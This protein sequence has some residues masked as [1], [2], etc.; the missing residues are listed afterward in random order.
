MSDLVLATLSERSQSASEVYHAILLKAVLSKLENVPALEAGPPELGDG[1]LAWLLRLPSS[2]IISH[3]TPFVWLN[4]HRL[5]SSTTCDDE[6]AL[7]FARHLAMT[8]FDAYYQI[9]PDGT[10]VR[11]KGKPNY[12]MVVLPDL[13]IQ[14]WTGASDSTL[15]RSSVNTLTIETSERC[16]CIDLKARDSKTRL[17][18]LPIPAYPASYLLSVRDPA[19][20]E[21]EYFD[22]IV[23]P[24][25]AAFPQAISNALTIIDNVDA[26]LASRIGSVIRWYVP[27]RSPSSQVHCSFSSTRLKGIIFLSH[28]NNTMALAEAIVHEF[29]HTQLNI[30]MDTESLERSEPDKRFYSPW[31]TDPRPLSGLI[32]AVYVF[33]G[34]ADFLARAG[35]TPTLARYSAHIEAQRLAIYHKLRLGLM[36]IPQEELTSLGCAIT[37]DI[38]QRVRLLE[39]DMGDRIGRTPD[40]IYAH[41]S[42]WRAEHP[43][44]ASVVKMP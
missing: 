15:V 8:S 6:V 33:S 23:I 38:G 32:H 42:H 22:E 44:L 39:A 27:I 35:Q 41:V 2:K 36:Q 11:L 20:F 29:G 30:L 21:A 12:P 5:A 17:R 24:D 4:V 37:K 43:E 25:A 19:L 40:W 31:R 14:V 16:V 1:K 7:E 26:Q 18:L 34:V 28:T 13:G 10:T 9:V 3:S